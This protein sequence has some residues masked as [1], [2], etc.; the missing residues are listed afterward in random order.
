MWF[1]LAAK[2][3]SGGLDRVKVKAFTQLPSLTLKLE[4]CSLKTN[5]TR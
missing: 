2:N 5:L 4:T 3:S 1:L